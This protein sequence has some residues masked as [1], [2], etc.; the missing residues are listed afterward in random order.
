LRFGAA[1]AAFNFFPLPTFF[2]SDPPPTS[3]ATSRASRVL[4]L[5]PSLAFA[6]VFFPP[7]PDASLAASSS[8]VRAA[9]VSISFLPR[10]IC[11]K[12]AAFARFFFFFFFAFPSFAS[13]SS[14][15]VVVVV[16]V[17]VVFRFVGRVPSSVAYTRVAIARARDVDASRDRSR[18]CRSISSV[19]P[20]R[21]RRVGRARRG[22]TRSAIRIDR[23]TA[24]V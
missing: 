5:S 2:P 17:V 6:F 4:V 12:N 8:R 1:A 10:A 24:R 7:L 13:S 19:V 16:V 3:L 9:S 15:P 21:R 22:V 23:A 18:V 20:R 14:R 11:A